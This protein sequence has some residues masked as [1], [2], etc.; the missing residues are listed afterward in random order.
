MRK[1]RFV[2]RALIKESPIFQIL[3]SIFR[4]IVAIIAMGLLMPL[5]I[6]WILLKIYGYPHNPVADWTSFFLIIFGSIFGAF[7][8]RKKSWRLVFY[9]ILIVSILNFI[10]AIVFPI[11]PG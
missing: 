3:S 4:A 8:L 9:I 11:P 7:Y 10:T 1:W 2:P 6:N 5:T